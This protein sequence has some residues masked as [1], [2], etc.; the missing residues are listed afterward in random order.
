MTKMLRDL[1]FPCSSPLSKHQ[2]END[3]SPKVKDKLKIKVCIIIPGI[4][5]LPRHLSCSKDL[6]RHQNYE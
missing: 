5:A 6:M 3:K 1:I 2:N 4:P